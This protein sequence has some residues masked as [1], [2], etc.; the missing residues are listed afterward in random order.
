MSGDPVQAEVNRKLEASPANKDA[1]VWA[2]FFLKHRL[3]DWAFEMFEE[4]REKMPN[5]SVMDILLTIKF[6]ALARY[7]EEQLGDVPF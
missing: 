2:E 5:A 4:A 7:R 3:G 6:T 1:L